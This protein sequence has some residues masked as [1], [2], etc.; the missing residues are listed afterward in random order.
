MAANQ[1]AA[2]LLRRLRRVAACTAAG[3]IERELLE[4][5]V[6]NRDEAA[7]EALVRTH[8]GMV[9]RVLRH[10]QDAEDTFQA[11]FLI[12]V[13]RAVA[14]VH[15]ESLA[16][17][18]FKVAHRVALEKRR[19][20]EKLLRLPMSPNRVYSTSQNELEQRGRLVVAASCGPRV[21]EQRRCQDDENHCSTEL[22]LQ[23]DQSVTSADH[24]LTQPASHE[25]LSPHLLKLP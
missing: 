9:W 25:G 10:E 3:L 16:G 18:L 22:G 2:P 6:K 7:F 8:S 24:I 17:W 19:E 12:L 11:T 13:R 15:K 1:K 23:S 5:F 4:R 20:A 21:D 14:I